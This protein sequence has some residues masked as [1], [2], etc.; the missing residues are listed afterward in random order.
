[1][2]TDFNSYIKSI[3]ACPICKE[4]LKEVE[5]NFLC[6]NCTSIYQIVDGII[7]LAFSEHSKNEHC[8]KSSSLKSQK[9]YLFQRRVF[10]SLADAYMHEDFLSR[11]KTIPK[12]SIILELGSGRGI[13]AYNLLKDG[14]YIVVSDVTAEIIKQTKIIL[15]EKGVSE[16]ACFCSINAELLPFTDNSFDLIYMVSSLHHMKNP[17]KALLE[18]YRCLKPEGIFILAIEPNYLINFIVF[19]LLKV[20]RIIKA[21]LLRRE[22]RDFPDDEKTGFSKKEILALVQK[23]PLKSVKIRPLWYFNGFIQTLLD[24]LQNNL[25]PDKNLQLNKTAEGFFIRFDEFIS[26]IPLLR[27]LCWFWTLT[28][29][30]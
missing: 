2:K 27:N 23:T 10:N 21:S 6:P 14:Y 16:R 17:F 30:K 12:D 20:M 7:N 1:M 29:V 19:N 22:R 3:L 8:S 13:D 11:I 25:F 24:L 26:K 15:A 28:S 5:S 4:K 18:I 9:D